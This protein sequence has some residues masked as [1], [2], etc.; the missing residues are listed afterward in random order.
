MS[1]HALLLIAP[2][3]HRARQGRPVRETRPA[4]QKYETA[5][6]VNTFLKDPQ[7]YLKFLDE[8]LVGEVRPG[9]AASGLRRRL[10]DNVIVRTELRKLFLDVHKRFYLVVCELH[11]DAPGLPVASREHVCE[12]GFVV[13][14]RACE[15]PQPIRRE[16]RERLRRI[17]ARRSQL[18]RL[19]RVGTETRIG[20][21]RRVRGSRAVLETVDRRRAITQALVEERTRLLELVRAAGAIDVLEGWVP[22]GVDRIGSWHSVPEEPQTIDEAIFPLTPLIADPD[23]DEHSARGRTI[24]FGLVPT[25][26]AD[27]DLSGAG[28]F[29]TERCYEL[30]CFV[31]RHRPECPRLLERNDCAGELV[32][33]EPS[34]PYRL[35]APFDLDGT[36][37]RPVSV[38]LPDIPAL[39]AQAAALPVRG[40]ARAKAAPIRMSSPKDS[41]LDFKVVAGAPTGASLKGPGFCHLAIPL[42]TIVAL[43]VFRLFLPIVVILFGLWPLLKL[44]FCVPPEISI[45][46]ELTA[47]LRGAADVDMNVA[48]PATTP[49]RQAV[50]DMKRELDEKLGTEPGGRGVGSGLI[51]P[52]PRFG[53]TAVADLAESASADLAASAP[54][55]VPLGERPLEGSPWSAG[56]VYEERVAL[57]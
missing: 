40:P 57:P 11:C 17:A 37:N 36:S 3:W 8:D 4:L 24:F 7:R 30:R 25:A 33:S 18:A 49:V 26:T 1:E 35:A 51:G 39:A 16:T 44:R 52:P 13:R 50:R 2:W 9:P 12:A 41:L 28:R 21:R 19:D 46:A 34:E 47:A 42:V 15:V 23:D 29:D 56:V 32:W 54:P 45:G 43:F 5:D 20:V 6:V 22:S 10:S 27:A 53:G 38:Q 55:D 31:R 48:L 14:R